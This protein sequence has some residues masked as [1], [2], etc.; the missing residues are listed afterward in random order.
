MRSRA[1]GAP[2]ADAFLVLPDV[3]SANAVLAHPICTTGTAHVEFY[4]LPAG[5]PRRKGQGGIC[6]QPH[7]TDWDSVRVRSGFVCLAITRGSLT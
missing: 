3:E 1:R 6:C 4:T 2:K 7:R 5:L